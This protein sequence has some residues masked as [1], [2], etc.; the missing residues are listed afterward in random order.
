MI[1]PGGADGCTSR[2]QSIDPGIIGNPASSIKWTSGQSEAETGMKTISA[3]T[4]DY[5]FGQSDL[6]AEDDS[7]FVMA[8]LV[9][10]SSFLFAGAKAWMPGTKPAHDE[11]IKSARMCRLRFES[12]FE[13]GIAQPQFPLHEK[14]PCG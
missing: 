4:A 5:A 14:G 6:R 9:R 11:R 10:P 12:G 1:L 13:V 8:G 7:L 3:Y 2:R